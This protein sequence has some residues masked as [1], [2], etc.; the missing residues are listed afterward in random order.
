MAFIDN[1]IVGM[2]TEERHDDIVE[3]VLKKMV[4]NDLLIKPENIYI[5]D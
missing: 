5:E 1:V 2:E 4:E 3:E